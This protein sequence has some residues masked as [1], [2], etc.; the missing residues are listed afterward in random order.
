MSLLLNRAYLRYVLVNV[1][2]RHADCHTIPWWEGRGGTC[3]GRGEERQLST[4]Y[5]RQVS[6]PK[7][8]ELKLICRWENAKQELHL[9]RGFFSSSLQ[10]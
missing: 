1:R 6:A 4:F 8:G 3:G 10:I 2:A 7:L 5:L 9:C